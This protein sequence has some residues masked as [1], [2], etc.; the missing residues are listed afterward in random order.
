MWN[1]GWRAQESVQVAKSALEKLNKIL[2]EQ[3]IKLKKVQDQIRLKDFDPKLVRERDNLVG[4]IR[5][6]EE[7]ILAQKAAQ[8]AAMAS[9][10]T[11][12]ASQKSVRS[13]IEQIFTMEFTDDPEGKPRQLFYRL[14]W[15]SPCPKYR[16][17]C[18]LPE[19]E[20]AILKKI[21][22]K[23]PDEERNCEKY[24]SL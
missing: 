1:E 20:S 4:Q 13:E 10:A 23:I 16:S 15:K 21:A 5:L 14:T 12:E 11:S 18:P 2:N 8:K 7:Q 6:Y 17:L 3:N 9:L 24:A 22:K 19:R